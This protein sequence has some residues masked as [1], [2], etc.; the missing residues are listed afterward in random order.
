MT[1]D[2]EKKKLATEAFDFFFNQFDKKEIY[3]RIVLEEIFK[4]IYNKQE[5]SDIEEIKNIP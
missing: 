5:E 4:I 2:Q 1:S 3:S